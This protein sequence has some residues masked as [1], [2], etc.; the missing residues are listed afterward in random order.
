L[1]SSELASRSPRAIAGGYG[2]DKLVVVDG[3]LISSSKP[4]DLPALLT[5]MIEVVAHAPAPA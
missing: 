1:G 5:A 2:P 4:E 3:R